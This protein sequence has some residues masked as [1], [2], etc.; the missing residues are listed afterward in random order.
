MAFE[1]GVARI[2]KV[3]ANFE[4][5]INELQLGIEEVVVEDGKANE[6]LADAE[7]VFNTIKKDVTEKKADLSKSK[8]QA[9]NI[10]TNI[11]K[12]LNTD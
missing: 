3:V 12:L 8:K 9:E 4:K 2:K 7:K 10:K 11:E 1:K 5:Q 6:K